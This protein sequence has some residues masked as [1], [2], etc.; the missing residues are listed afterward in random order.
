MLLYFIQ[1]TMDIFQNIFAF[2]IIYML[3]TFV[4]CLKTQVMEVLIVLKQEFQEM[5]FTFCLVNIY[6]YVLKQCK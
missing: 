2:Y 4:L 3:E 1:I 5:Y 6:S